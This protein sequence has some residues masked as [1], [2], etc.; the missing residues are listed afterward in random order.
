MEPHV[1]YRSELALKLQVMIGVLCL[2][3]MSLSAFA[4]TEGDSSQIEKVRYQ[5]V[6]LDGQVYLGEVLRDDG[7]EVL[8]MTE[9]L[10]K[11]YIPKSKISSMKIARQEESVFKGKFREVGPFTTRYYFTNNALPIHKGE[12]YMMI[13]LYGPE[14]HFAV[15]E[16]L[17]VGVMATWIASPIGLAVK[18]ALPTNNEK[19]NFSL[20]TIMLSSGYLFQSKG[21]G[22]LHWLSATY[23]TPGKN[24]TFSGGYA[25]A[26][27]GVDQRHEL[28]YLGD[29]LR[30]GPVFSLAGLAPVG[31]KASFL[32]DS[33]TF[34]TTHHTIQ[35][36]YPS[37]NY[38]SDPLFVWKSGAKVTTVLMPGMR[39]QSSERSA[40]QVALA[41][42][43]EYSDIGF[44]FSSTGSETRSFP[45][46]MCSWFLK[47]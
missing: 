17:S 19:L 20:G 47:L 23:G 21:Y 6:T 12:H 34:F 5:I 29:R 46:P 24:I 41:G 31:K 44:D 33:M 2:A 28:P 3:L 4:Q 37:Y 38:I 40:F 32:F 9:E 11:I 7:R 14:V 8:I 36:I 25:Y 1:S 18:Y 43:I 22:G 30:H 16:R 27:F 35:N 10:G 15:G 13:H 26:D 42:L 39:F 45:V